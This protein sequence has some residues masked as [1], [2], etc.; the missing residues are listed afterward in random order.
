MTLSLLQLSSVVLVL[1]F[2]LD[3]WLKIFAGRRGHNIENIC[4][5]AT[6]SWSRSFLHRSIQTGKL[7]FIFIKTFCI[8]NSPGKHIYSY[9]GKLWVNK[10]K[11]YIIFVRSW[12][13]SRLYFNCLQIPT[14]VHSSQIWLQSYC[15]CSGLMLRLLLLMKL[16][17]NWKLLVKINYINLDGQL[18]VKLPFAGIM[19]TVAE[20]LGVCS[21]L[22]GLGLMG[23]FIFKTYS[24]R[25]QM[26]TEQ[27]KENIQDKPREAISSFI[28][29]DPKV[30]F[31]DT[32]ETIK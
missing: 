8:H 25:K 13:D 10:L 27:I 5:S 21:F 3:L 17:I 24:N 15:L 20:I 23:L 6:F 22:T 4:I 32:S 12:W 31:K 14:L 30:L 16:L 2:R 26:E 9:R 11:F 28:N 1:I 7:Q 19:P 29:N 18:K